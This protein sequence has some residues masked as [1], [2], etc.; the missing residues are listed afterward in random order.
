MHC[1]S[2]SSYVCNTHLYSAQ[3]GNA[4]EESSPSYPNALAEVNKGMRAVKLCSNKILPAV[5]NLG[6]QLT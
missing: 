3:V 5:L 4:V 1:P 2:A 6:C